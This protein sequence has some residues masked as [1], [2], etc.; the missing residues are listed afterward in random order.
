MKDYLKKIFVV[1]SGGVG[2]GVGAGAGGYFTSVF[3]AEG[4]DTVH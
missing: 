4:M 3:C 1:Y 2:V